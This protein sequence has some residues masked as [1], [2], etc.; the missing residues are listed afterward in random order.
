MTHPSALP[1]PAPL[2]AVPTAAGWSE[3]DVAVVRGHSRLVSSRSVQPLKLL[4]PRADGGSCHVVLSSYGGGMLAG[5]TIRLRARVQAGARLFVGTQAS[6][7]V[8][9]STSGAVAGQRIEGELAADAVAV[10]LPDPVVPQAGSRYYQQQHW[11]LGPGALLLLADWLT[12]G[13]TDAGEQFAFSSYHSEL[14]I[15][16]AGRLRVLD[17]FSFEPETHIATSPANFRQYQTALSV[18]LVGAPEDARFRH[19][20][21]QLLALQ[22]PGRRE[23]DF[24]LPEHACVLSVVQAKDDAYVLRA[25]AR[26]RLDLQ[27]LVE[28]LLQ[29]AAAEDVL[30]Y[31]PWERKY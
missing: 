27:P 5:D 8:Y 25:A 2:P 30:G 7:K 29:L 26:S 6:T 1:G 23:L 19:L 21:Q 13:R 10:V 9:K 20:G 11:Q 4:S 18:Y 14:R 12:S 24:R 28:A 16:R 22:M 3:I 15:S 31:N 17:R